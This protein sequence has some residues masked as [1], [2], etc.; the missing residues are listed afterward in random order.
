MTDEQKIAME[1]EVAKV[2]RSLIDIYMAM[3]EIGTSEQALQAMSTILASNLLQVIMRGVELQR[4][5]QTLDP[6]TAYLVCVKLLG[7]CAANFPRNRA[8][9]N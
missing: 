1:A 9:A 2:T 7:V 3:H 4:D 5:A 6:N 8:S